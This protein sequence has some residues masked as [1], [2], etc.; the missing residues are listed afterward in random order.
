VRS[1]FLKL[2]LAFFIIAFLQYGPA[3]LISEL[4]MD[5]FT[6]A[7]I[8]VGA[9]CLCLP[10]L[11]EFMVNH[12]RSR[13]QTII[14]IISAVFC[15]VTFGLA[16]TDCFNCND[17]WKFVFTLISFFIIRIVGNLTSLLFSSSLQETFPAQIRSL[18]IYGVIAIGRIATI[19][20]PYQQKLKQNNG[21][22]L[23]LQYGVI[24]IV[25]IIIMAV[26]RE[27]WKVLP[28]EFIE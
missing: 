26:I 21:V 6:L 20:I 1:D 13:T 3:F 28:S 15:F 12:P 7:I 25:G 4:Q 10:F 9:Q 2:S 8:N 18:G 19:I 23:M 27:T 5:F 11:R 24:S 16:P 22:S 17:S 14:M